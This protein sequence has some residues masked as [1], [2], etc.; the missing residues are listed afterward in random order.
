M[1]SCK[2]FLRELNDYLDES[3]DPATKQHWQQHID[4]CPNCYVIV[5][6]TKRTL[7]VYKGVNEQAVP[8]EVRSRVWKALDKKMAAAKG[9]QAL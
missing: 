3:I 7:A 8:E 5:D 1:P 6:T 4:E 2:E 9:K